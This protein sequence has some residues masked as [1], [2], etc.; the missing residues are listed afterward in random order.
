MITLGL[1][2]GGRKFAVGAFRRLSVPVHPPPATMRRAA[3]TPS[4]RPRSRRLAHPT[5]PPPRARP[6]AQRPHDGHHPAHHGRRRL[7]PPRGLVQAAGARRRRVPRRL[8]ARAPRD[9]C[10]CALRTVLLARGRRP[11][12]CTQSNTHKHKKI[13]TPA[14]NT[15]QGCVSLELLYFGAV[16]RPPHSSKNKHTQQSSK[17]K[18]THNQ[19]HIKHPGDARAACRWSCSTLAPSRRATSCRST[20]RGRWSGATSS[21]AWCGGVWIGGLPDIPDYTS[22]VQPWCACVRSLFGLCSRRRT[23]AGQ[24]K[25]QEVRRLRSPRTR[26]LPPPRPQGRQAL[27][28]DFPLQA[29]AGAAQRAA[30]RARP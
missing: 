18:N 30:G 27:R 12:P 19:T 25:E 8:G 5:P 21:T 2:E 6:P 26:L 15:R 17:K 29:A 23:G 7:H 4:A 20:P 28:L 9:A 13:Q 22:N 3:R 1:R 24:R 11:P 14:M 10:G 16:P